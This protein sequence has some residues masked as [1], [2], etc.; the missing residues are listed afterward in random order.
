MVTITSTNRPGFIPPLPNHIRIPDY[1]SV[2]VLTPLK[3]GTIQ[4]MNQVHVGS[5]GY[6]A[7][8]V[9][10]ASIDGMYITMHNLTDWVKK[11]KYQKAK[12][13]FAKE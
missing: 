6:A 10:I 5:S 7:W 2:W 8:L 3:D 11:E 12:S 9:N 13:I 1:Y 4:I